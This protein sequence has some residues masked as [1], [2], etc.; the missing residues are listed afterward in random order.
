MVPWAS[1]CK[2]VLRDPQDIVSAASNTTR[3]NSDE[4]GRV[5]L[6]RAPGVLASCSRAPPDSQ[7]GRGPAQAGVGDAEDETGF[8]VDDGCT[9]PADG[10]W[11]E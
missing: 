4:E 8:V 3:F 7:A 10:D 2:Y 6:A 5:G 9:A 1:S 11:T